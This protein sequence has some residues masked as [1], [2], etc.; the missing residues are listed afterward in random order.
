[1]RSLCPF[2]R[3]ILLSP[4]QLPPILF[5]PRGGQL[6]SEV[7]GLKFESCLFLCVAVLWFAAAALAQW[8]DYLMSMLGGLFAVVSLGTCFGRKR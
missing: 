1:M 3:T 7:V 4:E 5:G 2:F 6:H 8:R